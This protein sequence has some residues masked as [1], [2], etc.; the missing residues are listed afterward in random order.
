MIQDFI[1]LSYS[2]CSP[3]PSSKSPLLILIGVKWLDTHRFFPRIT[4]ET[5]LTK[6]RAVLD[7]TLTPAAKAAAQADDP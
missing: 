2:N 5:L 6:V 4:H 7:L 3:N 1:G